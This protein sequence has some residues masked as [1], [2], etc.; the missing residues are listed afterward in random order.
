M[1]KLGDFYEDE[2]KEVAKY[3]RDAGMKVD[4]RTYIDG[5]TKEYNYLE[6]V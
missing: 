5:Y 6:V 1:L 3:L 4:I 2:A